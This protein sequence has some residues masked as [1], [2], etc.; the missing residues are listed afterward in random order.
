MPCAWRAALLGVVACGAVG[1]FQPDHPELL[2]PA[3]WSIDAETPGPLD[4]GRPTD[5][6]EAYD[7]GSVPSVGPGTG[8]TRLTFRVLTVPLGGRYAPRNIGAVWIETS[9]GRFVKTLTRWARQ[10]ARYLS[11]FATASGNN[12]VDATT[13]ATLQTHVVHEV[14]WDLTDT[15]GARV[16][17]G[18]YK[19]LIETTDRN[20]SGDS[21]AIPF[22]TGP[23][24]FSIAP[25]DAPHFVDMTL[26]L[27]R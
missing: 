23:D 19:I 3:A 7:A 10:R 2:N 22:S 12:L 1:C 21:L 8:P 5:A 13:S 18:D 17:D 6:S 4:A 9:A 26:K 11:R 27:E 24:P 20:S 25:E 14:S 15:A 16:A